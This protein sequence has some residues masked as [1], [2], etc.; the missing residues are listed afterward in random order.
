MC[1]V[2]ALSGQHNSALFLLFSFS[3]EVRRLGIDEHK[4]EKTLRLVLSVMGVETK[5]S[6]SSLLLA[7]GKAPAGAEHKGSAPG[8]VKQERCPK[9]FAVKK[10]KKMQRHVV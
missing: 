10:K 8:R 7:V 9:K 6:T 1:G 2:P 5:V 4:R 3:Q